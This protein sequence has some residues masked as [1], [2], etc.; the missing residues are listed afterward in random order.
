MVFDVKHDGRHKA[1]CVADG[2]LTDTPLESVY[3]GVVLLRGFRMCLFLA[4]LNDMKAYA[5]DIGNAYLEAYTSEKLVIKAGKE[6]GDQEGNLLVI[7]KALYGL[8]SSGLRFN[9]LLGSCLSKLGFKRS[10]CEDDIW[11]KDVGTHYE[12]V[13][14]YVDDLCIVAKDPIK[15]LDQ[16][17]GE[18]FNFKLKGSCPIEDTVHLGSGFSRDIDNVLT[19]N[20]KHYIDRMREAFNQRYPGEKI[21]QKIKSPPKP[22]DHPE[23][24]TSEF[25]DE[26][27]TLIY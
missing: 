14:T 5:T 19:M 8:K 6:F 18:P 26:D 17:Q 24:D 3:S 11:Y 10:L 13:A 23:L 22:C 7:S 20:P 1:R 12:Y 4:E 15:L 21:D 16:L 9:E 25:L 27:G 2:H